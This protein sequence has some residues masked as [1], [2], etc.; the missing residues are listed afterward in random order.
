LSKL[1]RNSKAK[2]IK[3]EAMKKIKAAYIGAQK[4]GTV[5]TYFVQLSSPQSKKDFNSS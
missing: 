4:D 3:I 5:Q 2:D 1:Y